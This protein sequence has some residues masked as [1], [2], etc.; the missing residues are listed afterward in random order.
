[1]EKSIRKF[2]KIGCAVV[3]GMLIT[4]H[5]TET[6]M[7]GWSGSMNGVAFGWASVNVVSSSLKE[8]NLSTVNMTAPGAAMAPASYATNSTL[9]NGS[10][11]TTK[12][13]I[14]GSSG[15]VWTAD[16]VGY[17]GDSTDNGPLKHKLGRE[18]DATL[19]PSVTMSSQSTF[20]TLPDAD[21]GTLT[22]NA[23]GTAGTALWLQ[24]FKYTGLPG[25]VPVD[26]PSTPDVNECAD[27]LQSNG[28]LL[29]DMVFVGPFDFG[30]C[31]LNI[32]VNS[33]KENFYFLVNSAT[34]S[35]LQIPALGLV[36]LQCG[37]LSLSPP[38]AISCSGATV[39]GELQGVV[40]LG[41]DDPNDNIDGPVEVLNAIPRPGESLL[42]LPGPHTVR[43][44]FD[45]ASQTSFTA[46]QTVSVV[47]T[48]RPIIFASG[49]PA[50]GIIPGY[51]PTLNQIEAALGTAVATDNCGSVSPTATTTAVVEN[52]CGR[53][54]TRTWTLTDASGNQATSVSRTA[55]WTV[56]TT[57]P[58]ASLPALATCASSLTVPVPTSGFSDNCT[59]AA[60]III[61]PN[62][63]Q[64]FTGTGPGVSWT[65][66]DAA[67]NSATVI[68]SVTITPISFVGFYNPINTAANNCT[69]PQSVSVNR[70]L[71]VKFDMKCGSTF[72]TGGTPPIVKIYR[73]TNCS[74]ETFDPTTPIATLPAEYLTDWHIQY[75]I[76]T[77][78][79]PLP[80][81]TILKIVVAL[82]DSPTHTA[83]AYIKL[84]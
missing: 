13:R 57:L 39:V 74:P 12:A 72:I 28:L 32:F 69:S 19:C 36:S 14:Q 53:S 71:P 78:P 31:G 54:Q 47:D 3:V 34:S 4:H 8:K 23:I 84:K 9:P 2:T 11:S 49:I 26:D 68:Q 80:K 41:A 37:S 6:A 17:N 22:V 35:S 33:K 10:S 48:T 50:N 59:A 24:G 82:P 42:Q 75:D 60:N 62:Q 81:G 20:L 45:K 29:F 58:T 55:T 46:D 21:S 38:S 73:V 25:N 27:Y 70:T 76:T 16:T 77:S 18:L 64:V 79:I 83:Y 15:Y 51:N 61:T 30:T 40:T 56:D 43:W 65:F 52:G 44:I 63:P 1:M 5:Q 67:G 7:A 66:T